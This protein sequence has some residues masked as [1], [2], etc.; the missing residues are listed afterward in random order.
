VL[1]VIDPADFTPMQSF[2]LRTRVGRVEC[3]E[4]PDTLVVQGPE[5]LT[6][7][8]EVNGAALRFGST[9]NLNTI[10]P[11]PDVLRELDR[12]F[13]FDQPIG[14][15][16]QIAVWDGEATTDPDS[17]DAQIVP[18]GYTSFTCLAP[19]EDLNGD[20]DS[21]ETRIIDGCGWTIPRPLTTDE[22]DGYRAFDGVTLNYPI[23]VPDGVP[24][25]RNAGAGSAV[26]A[27]FATNTPLPSA[28]VTSAPAFPTNT[29]PPAFPTNTPVPSATPT[30][31][32]TGTITLPPTNTATS[33]PTN[34]PTETL[35][36]TATS[37]GTITDVPTAT[38]TSSATA[39]S[40][41]TAT[42]TA[43]V[44]PSATATVTASVTATST[45]TASPS[46]SPTATETPGCPLVV[47]DIP[48]GD[49]AGL[50]NAILAANDEV[51]FPG[52]Q[53]IS[54]SGG[55]T[56]SF[57]AS[58]PNGFLNGS[59]ALPVVTSGIIIDGN[60]AVLDALASGFRLV[61]VAGGSLSLSQMTITNFGEAG[62]DGGALY[63]QGE[64]NL[65]YVML[66]NNGSAGTLNGG[67]VKNSGFLFIDHSRLTGNSATVSGGAIVNTSALDIFF[68]TIDNNDAGSIGGGIAQDAAGAMVLENVTLSGNTALIAGAIGGNGNYNFSFVTL[69]DN[70]A[71]SGVNGLQLSGWNAAKVVI[72]GA[73]PQCS[74][75]GGSIT[76]D[77]YV[78]DTSCIGGIV[79]PFTLGALGDYGGGIPTHPIL[80]G[81]PLIDAAANCLNTGGSAVSIDQRGVARP[82]DGDGDSIAD[83]DPGAYELQP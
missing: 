31:T 55:G 73:A 47:F 46:P 71:A 70:T 38:A 20:G 60:G 19:P 53:T 40:T 3:A 54:L 68:S 72:G 35:T 7:Q 50:V 81:S 52:T 42:E 80:T 5:R 32:S 14:S 67:A 57:N 1:A 12:R 24:A 64:L 15:L 26:G 4:A 25:A 37:T 30:F 63:N 83:C 11:M 10:A 45:F 79:T 29:P 65:S 75:T 13:D 66:E 21:S 41:P 33:T 28:T 43:T 59:S 17:A 39:S 69:Y 34:T 44:T 36:S 16:L 18:T 9:I 27:G 22:L 23:R 78:T 76:A 56:Y 58:N 77:V 51:C 74:I 2:Y 62:Q 61:A 82:Q 8:L 49:V 48:D 6:I